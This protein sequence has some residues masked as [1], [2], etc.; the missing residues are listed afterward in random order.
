MTVHEIQNSGIDTSSNF[1]MT[2]K[3]GNTINFRADIPGTSF[4]TFHVESN[5]LS[6]YKYYDIKGLQSRFIGIRG[7][8]IV[9][10][11]V[12]TTADEFSRYTD[13]MDVAMKLLVGIIFLVG[14]LVFIS[15]HF[16]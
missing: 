15:K 12:I 13:N 8:D 7:E 2:L 16:H 1:Q 10:I 9:S 5:T 6:A 11:K 14:I 3:N 4:F